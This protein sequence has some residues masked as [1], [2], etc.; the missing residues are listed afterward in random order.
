MQDKKI[1]AQ[2][3]SVRWLQSVTFSDDIAVNRRR[4][5]VSTAS[6]DVRLPAWKLVE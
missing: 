5:A 3:E 6:N 1:T 2:Q 4:S